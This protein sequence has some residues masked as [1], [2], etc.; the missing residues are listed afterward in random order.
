M[1]KS[2][3]LQDNPTQQ[4][5]LEELTCV[6]DLRRRWAKIEAA[7]VQVNRFEKPLQG[8]F[9]SGLYPAWQFIVEALLNDLP[10]ARIAP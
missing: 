7:R 8:D 6:D 10:E 2:R 3:V 5:I 1:V 4:E 9:D